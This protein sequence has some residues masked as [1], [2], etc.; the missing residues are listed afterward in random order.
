MSQSK[1]K[2]C[3][4]VVKAWAST[5]WTLLGALSHLSSSSLQAALPLLSPLGAH[6]QSIR[7]VQIKTFKGRMDRWMRMGWNDVYLLRNSPNDD[8]GPVARVSIYSS[9]DWL[10]PEWDRIEQRTLQVLASNIIMFRKLPWRMSQSKK[11]AIRQR[12]KATENVVGLLH[13]TGIKAK[14]LV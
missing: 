2:L 12:I 10:V 7:S 9:H 3:L 14:C 11:F 1:V 4:D 8:P 5:A 6:L 13:S